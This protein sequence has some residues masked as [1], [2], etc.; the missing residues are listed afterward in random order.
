MNFSAILLCLPDNH[1]LHFFSRFHG[2]VSRESADEVLAGAEG[3]YLI[4]ESQRQPGTHTL[5]L[6]C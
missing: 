5:A 6:R 4:R 1:L 2:R 3:A